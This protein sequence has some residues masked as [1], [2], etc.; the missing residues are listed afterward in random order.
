MDSGVR[1]VFERENFHH[2]I[3]IILNTIIL[4]AEK[5]YKTLRPQTTLNQHTQCT[6]V[7]SNVRELG[8]VAFLH[9]SIDET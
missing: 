4:A 2:I 1:V 7:R 8:D 5:K 3:I 6:S 9:H